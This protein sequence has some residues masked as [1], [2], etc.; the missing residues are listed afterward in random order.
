MKYQIGQKFNMEVIGNEVKIKNRIYYPMKC[1]CGKEKMIRS[2]N[3]SKVQ[4]CGCKTRNK[5]NLNSSDYEKLYNTWR[6]MMHRCY[7]EKSDRYY[8]YG[9][10]GIKICEEWKNDFKIFAKWATDNGWKV[11]L[12]IE[13]KDYNGMYCPENCT[14]IT[15]KEQA[16][17]KTNNIYL[18]IDGVTKC[19]AEWCENSKVQAKTAYARYKRG[20]RD[21][22]IILY[23]GNIRK[24]RE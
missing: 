18:T 11:G 17:N 21:P 5:V 12:S 6:N 22:Y 2:D 23:E 10:R 14:F 1:D 16:R 13:R 3:V 15:M 9:A 24:L 7:D 4:S 19:I 8:T 20:Y